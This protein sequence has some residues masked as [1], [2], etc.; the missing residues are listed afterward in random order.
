MK[1]AFTAAEPTLSAALDRRFGRAPGFLVLDTETGETAYE[2][3]EQ[4]LNAAQGA[5]IQ[6]AQN[7]ASTGAKAVITG[8]CGPKAFRILSA[9]NIAVYNT[10]AATI[11]DALDLF[12]NGQ[13][14]AASGADVEGHWA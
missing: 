2:P 4:N 9:S 8:H 12:K 7:V 1:I 11:Q 6:A 14:T 10:E 5:G 3:N 13:L